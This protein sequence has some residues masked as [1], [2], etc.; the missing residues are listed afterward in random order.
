MQNHRGLETFG[1]VY[2]TVSCLAALGFLIAMFRLPGD[3]TWLMIGSAVGVVLQGFSIQAVLGW[4]SH[5]AVG[6]AG[7][8]S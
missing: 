6:L 5:M 8:R 4:M 1:T 7:I 2:F 3:M